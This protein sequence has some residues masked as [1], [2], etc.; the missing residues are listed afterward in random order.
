MNAPDPVQPF[1]FGTKATTL[2]R[3]SG[4]RTKG[5]F[6][7]QLI[8]NA[9]PWR[10]TRDRA[11]AQIEAQFP[12]TLVAV[13]S[14][15]AREDQDRNSNAGAFLSLMDIPAEAAALGDAID[16]VF[17]SYGGISAGDQVLVQPMVENV[18]VSG[19]VLSRD[20]DTGSP[21]IVI[22]YDDF[23][24][25]TDTVTGGGESKT[26]LVHRARP[27]A[28]K[29]AR[30]AK[31]LGVVAEL[32]AIIGSNEL[33]IEFCISDADEIFIL[34]VRPLAASRHW[35]RV[36]DSQIDAALDDIRGRIRI[37]AAPQ[38][39]VSGETTVF[40]EMPDWN[41]AEIIG[42]TPRP[43]AFSLYRRLITDS[44]WARARAEM[45]YR[46]VDAPLIIGFHGRPFVDVRLSLNSLLPGTLEPSLA[47][48]IVNSQVDL[49]TADR[50]LHDKL[51]FEV[52]ITCRDFGF[53][54]DA[55]RLRDGGINAA[56]IG[57]FETAL[58]ALTKT[59][60]ESGGDRIEHE[61]ALSKPLAKTEPVDTGDG[62]GGV[63]DLL[64]KTRE[65]GTLPFAKLA[66]DG[67]IGVSLLRSL[68]GRGALREEDSQRFMRGIRTVSS[69]FVGDLERAAAGDLEI[70]VVIQRYGHLRPGTYDVLS[71]RYDERP[72]FFFSEIARSARAVDEEQAFVLSGEQTR[73]I[74]MLLGEAGY[75]LPPEQL[76]AFIEL[77]I[78]GREQS[79]FVF[80]RALSNALAGLTAW[81]KENGLSREDLSFLP[82][83][84]L[85]GS[86]DLPKLQDDV[87]EEKERYQITRA[88]RL[89]HLIVEPSD[90]D[91]VRL[92]MWRPNFITHAAVTAHAVPAE[93][94]VA[95]DLTGKIVVI[96]SADPGY[97]WIFAHDIAGLVT[98]FGG[99]NSHMA[100]RCAEFG[101]PAA[102]GCGE[103]LFGKLSKAAIIELNCAA[104]I[105]RPVG[106]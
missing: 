48:R 78:K 51:E 2:E 59:L 95:P 46:H 89:P 66:R 80:T 38:A 22:D 10:L 63:F 106:H 25:R 14:S 99:A 67:F 6:C 35:L 94:G 4:H 90:I 84:A 77:A 102:I 100:I 60:L 58:G 47:D 98:E 30:F 13:R 20:L 86:P 87:A 5:R 57:L 17:A 69:D 62:L 15:S 40:G 88:I 23:S 65:L 83:D 29:S 32:E 50:T 26:L 104:R 8:I 61:I 45:G 11:L 91:V 71:P 12:E 21:Y 64:D 49:L 41:P 16:R 36:S 19:V 42:A 97:D 54:A 75:D 93:T 1:D 56:D 101:L 70:S 43:L 68:V 85:A 73:A 28:V 81:S 27:E 37:L 103:Q 24:G 3:L 52:A 31:L 7:A 79:K 105:V 34:Q 33:D 44:V 39:G 74:S 72:E 55:Q 9:N 53:E 76:M 82:I 92:P 96:E 18:A